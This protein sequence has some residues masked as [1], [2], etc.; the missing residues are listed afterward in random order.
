MKT[1]HLLIK[2]MGGILLATLLV[3]CSGSGPLIVVMGPTE[4]TQP[5]LNAVRTELATMIVAQLT[6]NAPQATATEVATPLPS[7][8]PLPTATPLPTSTPLPTATPLPTS[9]PLVSATISSTAT[10]TKPTWTNTPTVQTPLMCEVLDVVPKRLPKL[11]PNADFDAD[12]DVKNTGTEDWTS[13]NIELS[14]SAGQ[15]MQKNGANDLDLK[16]NIDNGDSGTVAIDMRAP[17]DSGTY[18]TTW[19]LKKAGE[20]FCYLTLTITVK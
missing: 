10:S 16:T 1:N 12:S 14:Y 6:Q 2:V 9:T 20:A 11:D 4:D 18:K 19:V 17:G 5:T 13:D 7:N 3:S 8:T 15:Q